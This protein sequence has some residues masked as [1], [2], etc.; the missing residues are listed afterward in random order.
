MKQKRKQGRKLHRAHGPSSSYSQTAAATHGGRRETKAFPGSQ[1]S[2]GF[3]SASDTPWPVFENAIVDKDFGP[4]VTEDRFL[5]IYAEYIDLLNN[6]KETPSSRNTQSI[7]RLKSKIFRI[8]GMM[9]MCRDLLPLYHPML[10]EQLR[11]DYPR[12]KFEWP[13]DSYT[14]D[15]DK[16]DGYLKADRVRLTNLLSQSAEQGHKQALTHAY[17]TETFMAISKFQGYAVR[18]ETS[19]VMDYC[20]HVKRMNDHAAA[21]QSQANKGKNG[22]GNS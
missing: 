17:F 3:T 11:L 4:F 12:L 6:G 21:L 16:V 20:L 8:A 15:L 14:V 1:Q 10:S 22:R 5:D 7:Q 2:N 19:T 9:A 18:P 13:L